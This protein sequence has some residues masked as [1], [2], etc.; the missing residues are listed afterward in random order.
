MTTAQPAALQ[1]TETEWQ[2][3]VVELAH[4]LGWQHLHVRRTVGR[5]RKWVT[6]TNL[7]GW[8]DLT[9]IRPTA[10]HDGEIIFAELKSEK[11][12]LDPKQ[13]EVHQLLA[14][15]G[16]EVYVWRPSDLEAVRDRLAAWRTRSAR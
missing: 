6:A 14:R 2:A 15:A 16:H 11:G 7:E 8:P 3:Q 12:R 9:L 13:A 4:A 1:I 5:G 10:N